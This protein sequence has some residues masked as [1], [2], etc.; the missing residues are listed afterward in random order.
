MRLFVSRCVCVCVCA[1]ECVFACETEREALEKESGGGRWKKSE[2][3]NML[4]VNV[5]PFGNRNT[6]RSAIII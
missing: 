6:Y 2:F 1:C 3:A 5:L 4:N